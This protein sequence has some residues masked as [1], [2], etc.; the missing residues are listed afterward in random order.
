MSESE[1]RLRLVVEKEAV[2]EG[3]QGAPQV[4]AGWQSEKNKKTFHGDKIFL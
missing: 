4:A 3:A 1:K 2:D